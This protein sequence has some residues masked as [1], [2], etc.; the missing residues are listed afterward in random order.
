MI[1]TTTNE[2]P[3]RPVARILGIARGNTIRTRH[4]GRALLAGLAALFGGE[5]ADYTKVIAEARE[6]AMDRLVEHARSF[7]ADAVIGLRFASTE[8]M[9]NAAEILVYGT[10]VELQGPRT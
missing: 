5:I 10:A 3:G 2:V 9:R 8:V 1:L 4:M 6:Q 7:G